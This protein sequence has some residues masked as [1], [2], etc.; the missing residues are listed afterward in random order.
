MLSPSLP[1]RRSQQPCTQGHEHKLAGLAVEACGIVHGM[2]GC[3][4]ALLQHARAQITAAVQCRLSKFRFL[5][6]ALFGARYRAR[7]RQKGRSLFSP[8]HEAPP[9]A[10]KLVHDWSKHLEH[11]SSSARV[12]LSSMHYSGVELHL[13]AKGLRSLRI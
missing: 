4:D 9:E 8:A 2:L 13:H 6:G 10:T 3:W 11:T 1:V 12:S 5:W 7:R